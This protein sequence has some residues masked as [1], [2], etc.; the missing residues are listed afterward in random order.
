MPYFYWTGIDIEGKI[1][2][3]SNYAV[4]QKQLE[5]ILLKKGIALLKMKKRFLFK[6][7]TSL[8]DS[9]AA[10]F[11]GQLATLLKAH[12]LLSDA[13]SLIGHK[14]KNHL[15]QKIAF[16]LEHALSSG[17]SAQ[18]AFLKYTLLNDSFIGPLLAAGDESGYISQALETAA[19]YLEKKALFSQRVRNALMLPAI[20]TLFLITCILFV[21]LYITPQLETLYKS[22]GK[23]LPASTFFIKNI[24]ALFTLKNIVFFA[25]CLFLFVTGIQKILTLLP[26]KQKV[27]RAMCTIPW[28]GSIIKS[29]LIATWAQSVSLLL[30]SGTP[31]SQ[32]LEIT[33]KGVKNTCFLKALLMIH[34]DVLRGKSLCLALEKHPLFFNSSDIATILVGQ[35][36]ENLSYALFCLSNEYFD[37]LER[38]LSQGISFLQPTLM[39][40]LGILVAGFIISVY[41]PLLH[42]SSIA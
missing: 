14:T 18:K 7:Q 5:T 23:D 42:F 28:Y 29:S 16:D 9:D 4:T 30:E 20:T 39:L 10:V 41:A 26:I 1:H 40:F 8:K 17:V 33:Q 19:Q 13:C 31:L 37:R 21:S 2:K 27:D 34:E 36:S 6:L 12:I 11:F 22:I 15:T 35:E 32:S 24:A 25:L 38:L 3:G